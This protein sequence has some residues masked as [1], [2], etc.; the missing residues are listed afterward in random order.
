MYIGDIDFCYGEC[1]ICP[2]SG[3]CSASCFTVYDVDGVAEYDELEVKTDLTDY[4][5]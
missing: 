5:E 4:Y 2:I 3:T 1:W